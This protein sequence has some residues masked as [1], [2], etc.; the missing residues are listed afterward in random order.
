MRDLN[1]ELFGSVA[2]EATEPVH[3]TREVTLKDLAELSELTEE[4]AKIRLK[5]TRL[6]SILDALSDGLV[7]T[8]RH[9]EQLKETL[10]AAAGQ[11]KRLAQ[12]DELHVQQLGTLSD[13]LRSAVSQIEA[14]SNAI[15]FL[16]NS[17]G[18][19]QQSINRLKQSRVTLTHILLFSI[20]LCAVSALALDV[21][22]FNLNRRLS[23]VENVLYP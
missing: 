7:R 6:S 11:I 16:R 2:V 20:L 12:A 19:Q 8:D 14:H 22:S 5:V 9:H 1:K 3:S 18:Q 13:E 10:S 21:D 4:Q 23:Q 15:A 17:D